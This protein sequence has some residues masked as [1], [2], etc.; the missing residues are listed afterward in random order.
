MF[1]IVLFDYVVITHGLYSPSTCTYSI[2][3]VLYLHL[4]VRVIHHSFITSLLLLPHNR[5]LTLFCMCKLATAV[6]AY[7]GDDIHYCVDMGK[8]WLIGILYPYLIFRTLAADSNYWSGAFHEP[9]A[10]YRMSSFSKSQSGSGSR[11]LV[12]PT[13]TALCYSS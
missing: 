11:M 12:R 3:T 13:R 1:N 5:A 9:G 6:S 7:I 10:T 4:I 2:L 8:S